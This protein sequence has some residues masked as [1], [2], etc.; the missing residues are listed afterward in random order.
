MPYPTS[1][2]VP[3]RG[4]AFDQLLDNLNQARECCGILAHLHQT[5]DGVKDKVMS[6]A[7]LS[8]AELLRKMVVKVTQIAQGK[9][10]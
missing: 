1:A 7:W 6:L 5:E 4:L 2:G 9:L 8:V 3:T 10:Q